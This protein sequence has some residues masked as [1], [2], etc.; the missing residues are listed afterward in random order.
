M[1]TGSRRKQLEALAAIALLFVLIARW[2]KS[3]YT[4][5][6]AAVIL[7]MGVL[8]RGFAEILRRYWM[9]LGKGLGVISGTILLTLVYILAV[10]PLS[11]FARRSGKF[12]IRLKPGGKSNFKDRAHRYEEKDFLHPW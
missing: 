5:Y 4:L 10:L 6:V 7:V 1:E 9:K 11:F 12:S 2:E 8:W 3:W